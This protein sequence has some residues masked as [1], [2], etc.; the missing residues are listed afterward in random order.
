[1]NTTEIKNNSI[2]LNREYIERD[3][4]GIGILLQHTSRS[5]SK[6]ELIDEIDYLALQVIVDKLLDNIAP[7]VNELI[8]TSYELLKERK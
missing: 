6:D 7:R 3:I 4:K 2:I 1:M 5:M 8:E